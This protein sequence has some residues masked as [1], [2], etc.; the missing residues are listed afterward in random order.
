[1][2][3]NTDN[4]NK[5]DNVGQ[6][7]G[8]GEDEHKLIKLFQ[9]INAKANSLGISVDTDGHGFI[10]SHGGAKWENIRFKNTG[11]LKA[12]IMGYERAMKVSNYFNAEE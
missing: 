4:N 11:E 1:M 6:V 9:K 10:M 5:N 3:G 12:F 8:S 7:E 2:S